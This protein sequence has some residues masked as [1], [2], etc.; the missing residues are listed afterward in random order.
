LLDQ[1]WLEQRVL[2]DDSD[3]LVVDKPAGI[4]VHGGDERLKG[5][6]V[7]RLAERL[8]RRGDHD[9]LGVHQRLDQAASGVLAFARN[10]EQGAL[11]ARDVETHAAK[12]CYLAAVSDAGLAAA[13]RLEHRLETDRDGISRVVASGGKPARSRFRVL[14]RGPGRALLAL[15]LETGR[16]HQLRAQ[17]SAAGA[18]IAGDALYGGQRAE[19]LLLHA[20]ELELP[21]SGR[22]FRAPVPAGFA[23]W[24]RGEPSGLPEGDALGLAL[25]DA[26]C[27]RWPLAGK[28]D[29][30]RLANDAGDGL[31]GVSIDRYA[32]WAVLSVSSD[33]AI[34]RRDELAAGLAELGAR[35]V[36][37]KLRARA[38]LRRV[39]PRQLAPAEPIWGEP[40]P[41]PLWVAEGELCFG[42]FLGEGLS[43]GLFVDQRGNRELV[44]SLARGASVLNL[45]A[46]TCSFSVAAAK[47]GASR[48]VSVD[49][50]G[51]ALE[52][53]RE[54][55]RANGLD[56]E[57]HRFVRA[58]VVGWLARARRRGDRFDLVV[59]DP[60]SFGTGPRKTFDVA[61][62]YRAVA[63]DALSLLAPGGRLL[64][65][66]HHRKT[67]RERLRKLLH[68]AL[69]AAGRQAVQMKDLAPAL[70]CPASP[71]GPHPSKSALVVAS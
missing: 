18:P 12:R 25:Q 71:D 10:R 34:A 32:D 4:V 30:H 40:A 53:G 17:L 42:V 41:A 2:A 1:P 26:A 50:S 61:R 57:R 44:R 67:S 6:V 9:Y 63:T 8:R 68:E 31:P 28:S 38:D 65:V 64:A 43:T 37:A 54:N 58:D 59:L 60:P 14:E 66:T 11:I 23:R 33:E 27:L 70:D 24:V 48:V 47:G 45:F 52:R 5:D 51:R 36:Y 29:V 20:H 39:D 49:L 46:Y 19:R 69:R 7:T 35:G 55:F 13:G 15:E 22:S 3:L 16:T 62:G 21:S 56:P